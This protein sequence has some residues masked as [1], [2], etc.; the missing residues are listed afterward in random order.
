MNNY[1]INVI[2]GDNK[3]LNEIFIISL[4][5][6]IKMICKKRKSELPSSCTYLNLQNKEGKWT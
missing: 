2:Y 4:I 1:K 3:S 6:D 5:K